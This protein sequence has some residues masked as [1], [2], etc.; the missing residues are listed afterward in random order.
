MQL[1]SRQSTLSGAVDIPGSKSH[2][3]RGVLLA[4]LAAGESTLEAPLAS[5]DTEA[6]VRVYSALGA[7]FDQG[8][9]AW[10]I[11]GIGTDFSAPSEVLDVGN[12][13]TT[14][15][16]AMGS[17]ALLRTGEAV[18][19]GDS[20]IQSRPSQALAD[21]LNDLGADIESVNGTGCAPYRIRGRLQGGST[22]LECKTS[23][24]L[25]SLLLACPLAP[26][27]SDIAVPLLHEK[28]Y[29]GI[30][31]DWL[32]F[33]GLR[34]EKNADWSRF[35]V[36]GGQC[37]QPFSRRVPADFSTATFFLAMGVLGDNNIVCRGLD[38]NDS[39]P[40]KA[41]IDYLRAMGADIT[42]ADNAVHC[43]PGV[44]NGCELD[45]NNTPDALPMMATAACFARG[46][47][48][49]VNVPQARIKETDRI[50]VMCAELG[51]LGAD[52]AE[53]PDG[54]VIRES[55]LTGAAVNGHHDHRVVMALA[56]AG[57]LIDG[58]T[59][60]ATAEAAAVTFPAFVKTVQNLGG[61]LALSD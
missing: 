35:H 54:L 51:K 42:T 24:Y 47:T 60:V 61:D 32:D 15:R 2:T 46:E 43:R 7:A 5:A 49:L 13:G 56:L 25:T 38:L 30:T 31:L 19:T 55:R 9:D 37:L 40:D 48:R 59:R 23:Q 4:A 18:I 44:L 36:P 11:R 6:A 8:P 17:L 58:E 39:Q 20:Q 57:T 26:G 52:I 29:V 50:A 22:S 27:D 41:V 14:L 33:I 10:H 12:S 21:A 28:P 45:L 1:I 34:V 3:I 16:V 53:L